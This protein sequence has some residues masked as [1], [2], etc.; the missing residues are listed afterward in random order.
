MKKARLHLIIAFGVFVIGLIIGSF[1]DLQINS[2]LFSSMNPFGL[3]ISIIG[4][5]PGYGLLAFMGGM[6]LHNAIKPHHKLWLRIIIGVLSVAAGLVALFYLGREIF[7]ANGF[8]NESLYYF[9]FLIYL[10]VVATI[11]VLGYF[12]GKKVDNDNLWIVFLVFFV[13]VGIA[14]MGGVNGLKS[15]FHRPRYRSIAVTD[16]PFF[17]WWKRCSSTYYNEYMTSFNLGKEEFKSFPSGHAAATAV[18]LLFGAM[19]PIFFPKAKK[20]AVPVFYCCLAWTLLVCFSRMLVG[21][22]FLSDVSM[23]AII[24]IICLFAANEIVIGNKKLH[25]IVEPEPPVEE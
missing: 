16:V 10:P 25:A 13:F 8:T 23:G 12:V 3:T 18:S 6:M 11:Y 4:M 22:H 9:G 5:I 20:A 2:A 17:P 21:A 19:F 7:S 15:L 1:L 24:M 14:L